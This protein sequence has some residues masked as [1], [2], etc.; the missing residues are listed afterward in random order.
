MKLVQLIEHDK[1]APEMVSEMDQKAAFKPDRFWSAAQYARAWA[2]NG[3]KTLL[4]TYQSGFVGA[5][6][7]APYVDA[8][9]IFYI[10]RFGILPEFR[11]KGFGKRAM[12][13]FED[14]LKEEEN[15]TAIYLDADKENTI[16]R[17]F[18]PTCGYEDYGE[19]E[20]SKWFPADEGTWICYIKYLEQEGNNNE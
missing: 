3:Y 14:K 10:A 18:Y 2:D 6:T 9:T 15:I 20:P 16:A 7:Y 13:L 12:K 19:R 8:P 1:S 17:Q 4:V 5:L 11:R